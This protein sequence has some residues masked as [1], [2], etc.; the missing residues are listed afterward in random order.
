M[1][2]R[3]L[4]HIMR[5]DLQLFFK[6]GWQL[7][8]ILGFFAIASALFPFALGAGEGVLRPI[9]GGII[10][11]SALLA[12][13]LGLP[14]LYGEDYADGTLE[15]YLL[16]PVALEWLVLAKCLGH[17]LTVC[18]PLALIAPLFALM[19]QLAPALIPWLILSLLLGTLTLTFLGSLGAALLLGNRKGSA[20]LSLLILPLNVPVL[21]FGAAIVSPD[22]APQTTHSAMMMLS[23]LALALIPLGSYASAALLRLAVRGQ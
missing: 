15:Q 7:T 13:M 6:N 17:W 2:L 22:A 20:V 5:H 14:S 12:S 4:W 8:Y 21:I 11:V 19:L 9:A 16:M 10:W 23:A 1:M 3:T 18:L